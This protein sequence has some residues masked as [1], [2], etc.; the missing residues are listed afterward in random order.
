VQTLRNYRGRTGLDT[1]LV[2]AAMTATNYSIADPQDP[3]QM[4]I[5]GFDPSYPVILRE[6]TLLD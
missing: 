1:K 5:V 3:R 2:V 4:D 6:F